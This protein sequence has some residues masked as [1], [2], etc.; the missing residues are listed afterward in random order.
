MLLIAASVR[1]RA[2]SWK[3]AADR[4]ESVESAAFVMPSNTRFAVAG[5]PPFWIARSVFVF[6]SEHVY[7][8]AGEHFGIAAVF[9]ADFAHHLAHDDF[10]VL[11]VDVNALR[12]VY[13]L[14]FVEDIVL[15]ALHALDAQDILRVD[16][17]A[18]ELRAGFDFVARFDS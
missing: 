2:V 8:F 9:D 17:A 13:R 11:I 6:E 18:V 16:R 14:Y 5:R 1:T 7:E 4:N 3:D 10:Y 15:H 12:T